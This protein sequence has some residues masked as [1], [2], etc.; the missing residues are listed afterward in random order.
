MSFISPVRTDSSGNAV[1]TGSMQQLGKDDFLK[2]LVSKLQNQDPMKPADDEAFV[3]Q[4]AQFS[5]LEQMGNIASGIAQ[6]NQ[7]SMIQAQGLNNVMASGLIGK[8]IKAQ[9]STLTLD[10]S[11]KPDIN[12]TLGGAASD[13]SIVIKNEAGE[14]I[15]TLSAEDLPAGAGQ[16]VWDGQ[17]NMGNRA[18]AGNYSVTMSAKSS[19]GGTVTSALNLVGVVK[20]IIYKDGAAYLMVNGIQVGLGDVL[21]IGEPGTFSNN[22]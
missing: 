15:R 11:N 13:V 20:Q 4:L 17:D 22:N 14:I 9:F 5:S 2:L 21:G 1:K 12:F 7:L 10:S 19:S 6:Q 18:P 8:E 3:A 16:I